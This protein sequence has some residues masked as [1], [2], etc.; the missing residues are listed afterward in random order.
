MSIKDSLK[1]GLQK[2]ANLRAL[3]DRQWTGNDLLKIFGDALRAKIADMSNPHNRLGKNYGNRHG[4]HHN[5][6]STSHNPAGTKLIRG[7]I[8]HSGRES[9][10]W[11]ELYKSRT[12][13]QYGTPDTSP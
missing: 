2:L 4:T 3:V 13:N 12:G 1:A 7:F 11:R 9:T 5:A 10:Y 8:R 6:H